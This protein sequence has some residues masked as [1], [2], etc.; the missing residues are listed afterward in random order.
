M[1][2]C[3][4]LIAICSLTHQPCKHCIVDGKCDEAQC[5]NE[6]IPTWEQMVDIYVT[7]TSPSKKRL[8]NLISNI[9][10]ITKELGVEITAKAA[11]TAEQMDEV[12]VRFR[13]RNLSPYTI[14]SYFTIL[15]AL[16]NNR[17]RAVKLEYRK[18]GMV[19]PE[20]DVPEV[21]TEIATNVELTEAQRLAIRDEMSRLRNS[22]SKADHRRFVWLWFAWYFGMRPA[23][24][25]QVKWGCIYRHTS[26]KMWLAYTPSKTAKKCKGRKAGGA[27]TPSQYAEIKPFIGEADEFVIPRLENRNPKTEPMDKHGEY[28]GTHRTLREWVS[29]FMRSIGVDDKKPGYALR[30]DCSATTIANEGIVREAQKLGHTP[31]VATENY[32]NFVNLE[33]KGE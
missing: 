8:R 14:K 11:V 23:D 3:P 18:R 27:I 9:K 30:K 26:G 17:R 1:N 29:G 32:V 31:K 19:C 24:I 28:V 15:A 33:L 6:T 2:T 5:V 4:N 10:A 16:T 20:I 22:K 7:A 12:N 21:K 25:G 13:S